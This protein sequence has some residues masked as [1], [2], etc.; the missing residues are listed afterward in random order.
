MRY[1][2]PIWRKIKTQKT[3]Q[4]AAPRPL[5]PRIIKAVN[6]EKY[7]DLEFKLELENS[8]AILYTSSNHAIIT[9]TLKIYSQ[10]FKVITED[11]I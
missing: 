7:G 4:I 1:Y 6:K 10:Y 11:M 5:H 8:Y 2:E 3:A 9:F